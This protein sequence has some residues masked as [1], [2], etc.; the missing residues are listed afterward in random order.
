MKRDRAYL[1]KGDLP[2]TYI[3]GKYKVSQDSLSFYP[4]TL[5]Y[6]LL[7][8][9]FMICNNKHIH[10]KT[11]HK[12]LRGQNTN[13]IEESIQVKVINDR[14]WNDTSNSNSIEGNKCG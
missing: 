9:L 6:L 14:G 2:M 8:L 5:T 10:V 11:E 12:E 1:Y 7:L 3:Y 4:C 13:T